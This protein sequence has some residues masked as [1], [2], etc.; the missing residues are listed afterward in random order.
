VPGLNCEV[1]FCRRRA[2]RYSVQMSRQFHM[3]RVEDL[4]PVLRHEF[5]EAAQCDELVYFVSADSES[6]VIADVSVGVHPRLA[7][8]IVCVGLSPP[9]APAR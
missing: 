1:R 5:D 7:Y 8:Y 3:I 6:V 2:T 4:K 9:S